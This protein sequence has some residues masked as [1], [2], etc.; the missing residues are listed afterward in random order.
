MANEKILNTRVQLKHDIEENWNKAIGFS[1]LPGEVIIYDVDSTHNQPR[2]KIGDGKTNVNDLPFIYKTT[3]EIESYVAEEIAKAQL[4]GEDIDLS[5]YATKLELNN[6]LE[7]KVNKADMPNVTKGN[8]KDSIVIGDGA[9]TGDYSLAS[10]TTDSS[11]IDDLVGSTVSSQFTITAPEAKGDVSMAMGASTKAYSTGARAYGV[12][13][14]AGYLGYYIWNISGNTIT[15]STNQ[16]TSLTFSRKKPN[17]SILGQ[18]KTG[19]TVSCVNGDYYP[20]FG[21]IT[22]VDANNGTITVDSIPFTELSNGLTM[23]PHETTLIAIPDVEIKS[24][25]GQEV[26]TTRPVAIGEVEFGFGASADGFDNIAAG[27]VSTATGYRNT[28]IDTAAFVTGRDNVGGFATLVGGLRNEVTGKESTAT[29]RDNVVKGTQASAQG[30]KLTALGNHSHIEGN[31]T[32]K[33]LDFI[34]ETDDAA[35][36]KAA[37]ETNKFALV[38]GDNSHVEG[39]NCMALGGNSHAHG[40][41][42]IASGGASTAIGQLTEASGA[43]SYAEGYSTKA[44]DSQA[45]AE[46]NL[47]QALAKR[48]HTEG[49]GTVATTENQHVQGRFN[50]LD[51][52]G[53]SGNYAHIVGGGTNNDNRKNIHTLDWNGGAWFNGDITNGNG[54]SL[55]GAWEMGVE[56]RQRLNELEEKVEKI[57]IPEIPEFEDTNTTY[58]L[59]KTDSGKGV[60]L[61]GSDGSE[62]EVELPLDFEDTNTTYTIEKTSTGKGIR[63]NGSDGTSMEIDL[64]V[65]D[66]GS[67]DAYTKEETDNLLNCRIQGTYGGTSNPGSVH[68]G[69][70][71]KIATITHIAWDADLPIT[72]TIASRYG[73]YTSQ[74]YHGAARS[75]ISTLSL[76]FTSV[77][78]SNWNK[79]SR[80]SIRAF[81][82]DGE[83][84][85]A[86]AIKINDETW[87]L[88]VEKVG[89][90]DKI[91]VLEVLIPY[92]MQN[93]I[94]VDTTPSGAILTIEEMKAI[95]TTTKASRLY[96]RI[97][98]GTYD[99]RETNPLNSEDGD[100]YIMIKE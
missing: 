15:L 89:A 77:N 81:K 22:A 25:L 69:Y 78:N 47:T 87:E 92:E 97:F 54:D 24:I 72:F 38:K 30:N 52:N 17:S 63:L 93:K 39:G 55:H 5:A 82:Y 43:Q 13:N 44:A 26:E 19:M 70:V 94:I 99:P 21:K 20:C 46:G 33:A 68:Q 7:L 59:Q 36:I 85:I 12:S 80:P 31:S 51:S 8:G 3:A 66:G 65:G 45:H 74:K 64:D 90:W 40:T 41:N 2:I 28:A 4:E 60:K 88:Y 84:M 18:W 11:L 34:S 58:T 96:P 42:T 16:H 91:N 73:N 71:T 98:S 9:A 32:N 6:G 61:V 62:V 48:A 76:T 53:K 10:G 23:A 67:V 49:Y 37:W 57:E 83:T 75:G 56:A 86:Y 79:G 35:T 14:Q 50:A 29:G 27:I 100:I 1:P 95:G